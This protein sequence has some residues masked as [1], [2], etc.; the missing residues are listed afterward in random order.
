MRPF[1]FADPGFIG[2]IYSLSGTVAF[3]YIGANLMQGWTVP[4]GVTGVVAKTWGAWGGSFEDP[5]IGGFGAYVRGTM[6]VTGGQ[7]IAI[8]VGWGGGS[9]VGGGYSAVEYPSGTASTITLA[10]GGGAA[11]RGAGGGGDQG[12]GGDGGPTGLAG[13]DGT[14]ALSAGR[15]GTPTGGGA[16]ASQGVVSATAGGYLTGGNGAWDGVDG[17]GGAGGAGYY[18]GG[19]GGVLLG[20][21]GGGG[22]GGSSFV[23][24]C[25]NVTNTG[26]NLSDPDWNSATQGRVVLIYFRSGAM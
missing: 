5:A 20:L 15:G 17:Y 16:G 18:G 24:G 1:T 2:S 4:V 26:V 8:K 25:S 14:I 6:Q 23:S 21:G 3:S 13:V 11:G 12:N 19:G 9:P 10:G 22:G 7:N